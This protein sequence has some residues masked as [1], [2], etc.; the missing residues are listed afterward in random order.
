MPVRKKAIKSL[1]Q[2]QKRQKRNKRILSD[3][4]KQTKKY[5]ALIADKQLDEAKKFFQ[6]TLQVK[7]D[8]AAKEG[9]IRKNTASRKKSRL[10]KALP[11][12]A[13]S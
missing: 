2:S 10:S 6:Q 11:H 7:I 13:K 9:M 3:L 5:K 1:R 12:Q 4:K 8:K